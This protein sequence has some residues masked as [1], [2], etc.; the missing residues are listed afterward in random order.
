M[1]KVTKLGNA[2]FLTALQVN[3]NRREPD[4]PMEPN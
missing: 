1:R 3:F 2:A 4:V